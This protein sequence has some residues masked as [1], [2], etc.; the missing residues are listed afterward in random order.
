MRLS[1]T[2]L[3][4]TGVKVMV[5]PTAILPPVWRFIQ[6]VPFQYS[7]VYAVTR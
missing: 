4:V 3:P 5:W 7:T 1:L 6:A 2:L